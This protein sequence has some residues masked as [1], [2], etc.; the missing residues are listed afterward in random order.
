MARMA[1][2]KS[3]LDPKPKVILDRDQELAPRLNWRRWQTWGVFLGLGLALATTT[4]IV[5]VLCA[6][7][8]ELVIQGQ[9]LRILAGIGVATVLC[10]IGYFALKRTFPVRDATGMAV[11][12]NPS[13]DIGMIPLALL[14]AIPW[15]IAFTI[16][17][18]GIAALARD[19]MSVFSWGFPILILLFIPAFGVIF[20]GEINENGC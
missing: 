13:L 14:L 11:P 9:I 20:P 10:L 12:G 16:P 15:A 1:R 19:M 5:V 18:F 6:I 8:V 7:A 3:V 2:R 17:F 4:N